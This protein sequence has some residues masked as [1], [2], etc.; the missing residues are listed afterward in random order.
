MKFSL[1][2]LVP[3]IKN[4]N[5]PVCKDCVYF[6]P[7]KSITFSKCSF[8]GEKNVITGDIKYDFADL[9]RMYKC[10]ESGKY[11]KSKPNNQTLDKATFF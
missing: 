4:M 6:I 7:D 2:L 9:S 8:F 5:Y 1:F 3:Q 10:G 11:Y